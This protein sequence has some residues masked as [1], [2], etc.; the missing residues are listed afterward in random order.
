MAIIAGLGNPGAEYM[1]TRHN[2]GFELVD[3][4]SEQLRIRIRPAQGP[5]LVGEGQF[6]GEPVQLV[7]P[8]TFMN[9]SGTALAELSRR[10][11]TPPEQ[12]LICYDDIH[13]DPGV[14]RLRPGGSAGGH[15]GL[16]DILNKLQTRTVPRLRIGIGNNFDRGRL[17]DYVLSEFKPPERLLVDQSLERAAEAVMVF[18]KAGIEQAM[19]QFN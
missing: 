17:S 9:R 3:L 10:Y 14:I 7:K 19:N 8:L 2:V 12:C 6:K 11:H 1:A 13:L 15:N 18:L 16:E 5:F 4:L